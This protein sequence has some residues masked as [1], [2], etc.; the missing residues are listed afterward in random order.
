MK[1]LSMYFDDMINDLVIMGGVLVVGVIIYNLWLM[2]FPPPT[3]FEQIVS[4]MFH[5]GPSTLT[6]LVF[7]FLAII[8]SGP[9]AAFLGSLGILGTC[10]TGILIS[11]LHGAALVSAALAKIGFGSVLIG[12]AIIIT[13]SA[14]LGSILG[15]IISLF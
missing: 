10:G 3:L 4:F 7:T 5:T 12:K 2:V 9:I 13:I 6:V 15:N 14:G 8:G 1:E 11:T